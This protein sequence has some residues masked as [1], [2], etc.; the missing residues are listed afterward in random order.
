MRAAILFS[1]IGVALAAC[2]NQC[3]GH[4]RCGPN[5]K[6]ICFRQ[7][8]LYTPY[9]YGFTGADCSQRTCPLGRAYD[10]LSTEVAG[11]T[12]LTFSSAT[13]SSHAKLVVNFIPTSMSKAFQELR[14]DMN[15][16]VRVLAIDSIDGPKFAW[17]L[18]TDDFFV[19]GEQKAREFASSASAYALKTAAGDYT[20]VFVHWDNTQHG[21]ADFLTTPGE[22]AVGDEYTFTLAVENT[23]KADTVV[24]LGDSNTLHQLVECS[25]RGSCDSALGKCTCLPGYTGEACQRT[26]CPNQCS[27]H[28]ACQ[29]QARFVAAGTGSVT[30]D[31][32]E[33]DQQYGCKCD[34]GYR[35]P[36]CSQ[37]ECPSGA[38][39]MGADGGSE[40]MDCSGR[41]LCNYGTGEC[42]CFRGFFG[43]R[44]EQQSTLV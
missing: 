1:A 3:S 43:E 38:D 40:G 26:V 15:F 34:K 44:C 18:D 37:V 17:K 19:G 39:V 42:Q 25:G 12:D 27:N 31:G 14:S 2:P 22:I 21:T 5:D 11:V 29:T 33:K 23:V 10:R 36:D 7:Q 32:Y 16:I 35:G 30:Y 41:G 9:R 13:G 4:G 20:G 24:D 28:G 8:G 6:C